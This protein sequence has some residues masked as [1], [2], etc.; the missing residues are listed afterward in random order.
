VSASHEDDGGARRSAA[1]AASDA[2]AVFSVL[3]A[4]AAVWHLLGNPTLAPAWAQLLLTAGVGAVLW[5]PGEVLPLGLLAVGGIVVAWEE[6]PFLGNHW[7]LAGFVNL[8]IL[9]AVITGFVR[10]RSGDRTDLANRLFPVARLSLL[11]FYAFAAFAKLNSAFLDRSVSCAVVFYRQ[12]TESLGLSSAQLDG[13]AWLEWAVIAATVSVEVLI[14]VLLVIRR[15]RGAGVVLG[16]AFHAVLALNRSHQLFDFSAVLAALFVL[17]LPPDTGTWA[18]ERL[19]SIRA[20]LALRHDRAPEMNRVVLVSLPIL[21]ALG[22][23][24]DLLS[25]RRAMDVGWWPWQAASLLLLAVSAGYLARRPQTNRQALRPHHALFVL[26]PVLVVL[27][28][29]TPYLEL[30]TGYSWAMYA[31]L[32]TVDGDTNHLL[33]P[34]TLSFTDEQGDVV[35]ILD[36][37]SAGLA[38]YRDTEYGLTWRQLQTYASEHPNMSLTYLRDRQVVTLARAGDDPEL[39]RPPPA[40]RDKLQLFRAVDLTN[41]ER[42]VPTF[43]PAR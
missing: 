33:L 2:V 26:V 22:V 14:P 8:A 34:G 30:K 12:T 1:G 23:S 35:T 5:R 36:T 43:G 13:A 6:A 39:V 4:L 28:G 32:R 9:Q 29:L 31:N 41:P 15:T 7:L 37:N 3:W 11:G 27:N 24:V 10:G 17:F 42:C 19:G 40:W 38:R 20:R 25:T 18:T 16:L 21:A